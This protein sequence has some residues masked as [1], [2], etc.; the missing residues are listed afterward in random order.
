[1]AF[2]NDLIRDTRPELIVELGTHW[3]E[4]YF[5][6][7]QTVEEQGLA[8]LCY[9]IDHWKGDGHAGQYGE[10]VFEDV[11]QYNDHY[12]S[13]FSYLLRKSFDDALVQ[14][15]DNS[16]GL[17]HIDGFH[18]YDAV[19][20]DF[21]AWLPKVRPDG[22]IL[23]HDIC[24][25]HQDFGV[26]RLWDDIKAQFRHTFEFHHS[27]GLGVL[28]KERVPAC[29]SFADLLFNSDPAVCEDI[30]HHYVVYASHLENLFGQVRTVL[31]H[32]LAVSRM[33]RDS[34][35]VQLAE[36]SEATARASEAGARE[37]LT[38]RTLAEMEQSLREKERLLIAAE[39]ANNRIQQSLS[40]RV[41]EPI[42]RIM[43]ILRSG[44]RTPA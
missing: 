4:A 15:A 12:Y 25:K 38:R 28:A 10:E 23:F 42:R 44:P 27:W 43:N 32:Q 3:G 6:F 35:A 18:T 22:I 31:E 39:E 8:S 36:A 21:R 26:W 41:T 17:L 2:A 11:S 19:T 1:M 29:S 33:E 30:R 20:R 16:I 9:A 37:E 5:T 14:F 7:C 13:Q 34:L 24:A 40:W